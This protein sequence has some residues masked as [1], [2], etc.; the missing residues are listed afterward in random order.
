MMNL[1]VLTRSINGILKKKNVIT[2]EGYGAGFFWGGVRP[3][4][5]N[6]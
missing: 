6:R 1:E 4:I 2:R 3:K 5:R